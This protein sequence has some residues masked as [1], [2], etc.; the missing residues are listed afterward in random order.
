M[1]LPMV[2]DIHANNKPGESFTELKILKCNECDKTF[3][4]KPG[5]KKH[6]QRHTGQYSYFCSI[7]RKGYNNG[8]NYRQ[9]MR[10]HEGLRY[11]CEYCSKPFKSQQA[12]RKHVLKHAG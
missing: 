10:G 9:H 4:S 8:Y 1:D 3:T 7:C 11:H 5:L 6:L 12:Y 2:S